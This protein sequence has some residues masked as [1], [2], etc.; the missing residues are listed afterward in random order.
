MT[1]S[2]TPLLNR[3]LALGILLVA[4]FLAWSIVI[5]PLI[6]L[7]QDR[8]AT[9][10][11]LGDRLAS[12]RATIRRIPALEQHEAALRARLEAQGGIWT[13]DNE[14]VVTASIQDLVRQ[15]V[16]SSDGVVKSTSSL[17]GTDEK[18]FRK[19]RVS[20]SIDATLE[21]VE[22]TLSAIDDAQPALFVE[23]MTISAPANPGPDKAPMLALDIEVTAYVRKPSK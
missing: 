6:G 8:Y 13:G 18:S 11:A 10:D 22:R 23:S 5:M 20:F 12:L 14:A 9:I 4:L 19:V 1:G 3:L 7:V 2:L 15:A 17:R 16:S 21:S